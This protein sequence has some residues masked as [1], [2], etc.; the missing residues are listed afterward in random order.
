MST[1]R[2]SF[3]A[4]CASLVAFGRARAAD[5]DVAIVGAGSAGIAAAKRVAAA[6]RSFVVLEA[7]SRIGGRA[8]TDASL[9]VPFDAGAEY[10]HWAERNPWKR[11]ADDLGVPLDDQETP[12]AFL[13]Y[14]AGQPIPEAERARRRAAFGAIAGVISAAGEGDRSFA[15]LVRG[16]GPEMLDAARGITRMAL[17]EEPERVSV[18]DYDQLWSGDD[19]IVPSGYGALVTRF[20]ADIPV[21]LDTAVTRIGWGGPA[22]ELETAAGT[23]RAAAAVLTRS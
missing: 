6:G 8:H 9:G 12:G 3:I 1:T 13:S 17:G 14:R 18:R 15:D 16:A 10:I 7:R 22:V 19:Y 4:G 20:G 11:I 21:R 5:V 23:V 2:R